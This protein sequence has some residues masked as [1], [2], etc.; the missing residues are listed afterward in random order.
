MFFDIEPR[1][2]KRFP[3]PGT[4]TPHP[5][6]APKDAPI[7]D[8]LM[9]EPLSPQLVQK[10]AQL[11]SASDPAGW[12]QRRQGALVFRVEGGFWSRRGGWKIW[13]GVK[14]KTQR[15]PLFWFWMVLVKLFQFCTVLSTPFLT[16]AIAIF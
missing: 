5:L 14:R 8:A 6:S 2:Q 3:S 12:H 9:S 7:I 11:S 15:R 16:H 1:L 10:I 4:L 13:G